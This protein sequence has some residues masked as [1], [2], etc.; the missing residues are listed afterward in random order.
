MKERARHGLW[1]FHREFRLTCAA[2]PNHA[3]HMRWWMPDEYDRFIRMSELR[4]SGY[5]STMKRSNG[6]AI[7]R[8]A[9]RYF[10]MKKMRVTAAAWEE[11]CRII[12]RRS[13]F[14]H[15]MTE[16][17][18][19]T[20]VGLEEVRDK[21]VLRLDYTLDQS[22]YD[23]PDF[24]VPRPVATLKQLIHRWYVWKEIRELRK[25]EKWRLNN[26]ITQAL[27]GRYFSA[28]TRKERNLLVS[29]AQA[30]A[31]LRAINQSINSAK[32]ALKEMYP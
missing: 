32:Y 5:G 14:D 1:R 23:P 21:S 28:A 31:D 6:C 24:Y 2:Y 17:C 18:W 9:N 27:N 25:R 15:H 3:A 8:C 20:G 13:G 12:A 4:H 22:C 11:L 7:I 26:A 29:L 19:R 16:K 10:R 30:K